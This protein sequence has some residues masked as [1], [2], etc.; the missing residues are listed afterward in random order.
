MN[1]LTTA[2]LPWLGSTFDTVAA[3]L[4]Q[5]AIGIAAFGFGTGSV[6]LSAVM[7]QGGQGCSLFVSPDLLLAHLVS[8]GTMSSS[9]PIPAA[10][11]LLGLSL[12]HQV[13]PLELDATGAIVS[14]TSTNAI[15]AT[16]GGF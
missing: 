5:I 10:G 6:P 8:A 7:P 14:F 3:G 9:L 11:Q 2:S 13:L 15:T 1:T 4:P 16:I 12:H